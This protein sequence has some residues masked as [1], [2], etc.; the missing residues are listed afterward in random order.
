MLADR[1]FVL[2]LDDGSSRRYP[3]G[4]EEIECSLTH[5]PALEV[6]RMSVRDLRRYVTQDP[7]NG[8]YLVPPLEG[9]PWDERT[10]IASIEPEGSV[11]PRAAL[12]F[13]REMY[14]RMKKRRRARGR[15]RAFWSRVRCRHA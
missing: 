6:L 12:P 15:H 7:A 13:Y 2:T 9:E 14:E 10:S 3:S 5:G 4:Y 11:R 1:P 8:P